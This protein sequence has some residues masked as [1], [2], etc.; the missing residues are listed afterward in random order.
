LKKGNDI[1]NY[2]GY[3]ELLVNNAGFINLLNR[4]PTSSGIFLYSSSLSSFY[5]ELEMQ[6]PAIDITFLEKNIQTSHML[7]WQ[8]LPTRPPLQ[9]NVWRWKLR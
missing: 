3:T 9:I 6:V 7:V 5:S 8:P 4:N 2:G 1:K